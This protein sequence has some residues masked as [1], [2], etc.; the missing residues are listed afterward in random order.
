MTTTHS[1]WAIFW[2]IVLALFIIW[3]IGFWKLLPSYYERHKAKNLSGYSFYKT[4][5][6]RLRRDSI[7][8]GIFAA[9]WWMFI[10]PGMLL[11]NIFGN[12]MT[13]E[14]RRQ[15]Q[16]EEARRIIA[17]YEAEEAAKYPAL[18]P[19]RKSR[20]SVRNL[21]MFNAKTKD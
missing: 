10:E 2:L 20:M 21:R 1:A 19:E 14:E 6:E 3:A 5:P 9:L 7:S 4:D 13:A 12:H 18:E 15:E 17:Q 16:V 11:R 8:E